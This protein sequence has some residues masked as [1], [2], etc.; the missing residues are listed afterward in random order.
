MSA[1]ESEKNCTSA[2]TSFMGLKFTGNIIV[3]KRGKFTK[4]NAIMTDKM[5]PQKW[6][7][8]FKMLPYS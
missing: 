2:R 1:L 5:I 8:M 7:G 3:L 4:F 6:I